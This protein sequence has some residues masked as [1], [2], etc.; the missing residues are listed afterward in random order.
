MLSN[1]YAKQWFDNQD[2]WFGVKDIRRRIAI[3]ASGA[4]PPQAACTQKYVC[5]ILE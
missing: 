1:D 4:V 3:L 5:Q 2:N